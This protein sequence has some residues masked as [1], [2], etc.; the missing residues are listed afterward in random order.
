M[1]EAGFR[2]NKDKFEFNRGPWR[3]PEDNV[4]VDS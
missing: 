1:S 2:N 3:L 4:N